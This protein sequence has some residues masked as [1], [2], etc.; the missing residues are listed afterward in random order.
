M[1]GLLFGKPVRLVAQFR[2]L[3]TRKLVK[4]TNQRFFD[5]TALRQLKVTKTLLIWQ[6]CI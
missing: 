6:A 1:T 5:L 3:A 4:K 2:Q